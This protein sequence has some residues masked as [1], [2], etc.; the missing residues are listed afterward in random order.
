MRTSFLVGLAAAAFIGGCA[1]VLGLEPWMN[2]PVATGGSATG[3]GGGAGGHAGN[4]GAGGGA[5]GLS[6]T[7]STTTSGQMD[8]GLGDGSTPTCLDGIQDG[9]E[10]DV[11][12]GGDACQPCAAGRRCKDG[13][14]CESGSCGPDGRCAA[15]AGP[16][17]CMPGPQPTCNDCILNGSETDV[18]CGGDACLP[19][20][21]GKKCGGDADCFSLHCNDG[22]CAASISGQA[23]KTDSDCASNH[24]AAGGCFTG[25]CCH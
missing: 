22:R 10:S 18:D 13:A 1:Q 19:C 7:S 6:A 16:P 25:A 9:L 21:A 12:C 15:E 2:P 4:G 11:D 8:G 5:G 17:M 23:C 24:C 20:G 3:G 14:D